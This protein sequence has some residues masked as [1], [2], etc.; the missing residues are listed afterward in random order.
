MKKFSWT[1]AESVP[2]TIYVACSGGVDSVATAAALSEWRDVSLLH[3]SHKDHAHEHELELVT[4][5]ANQ[6]GVTLIT[7]SQEDCLQFKNKEEHWR[8]ARYRW[9]HSFAIDIAT[10]HTL[11]DAVEWYLITCLRGRG[12]YMPHRNRNVVRPF[13]LTEKYRLVEYCKYRNL[14]WWEDP[15]NHNPDFS[16]RSRVRSDLAPAA[17]RCEPGLKNM[18]KRRLVEKI[19]ENKKHAVS[20]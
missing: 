4:K 13:L 20:N 7:D 18:V 5:L 11:D 2:N 6:L 1:Y 17:F 3:F 15:G 16:L 9:F 14:T 10:G 12:E 8:D 19:K